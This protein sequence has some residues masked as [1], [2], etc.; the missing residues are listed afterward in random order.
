[1]GFMRQVTGKK[2]RRLGDDNWRKEGPESVLQA[3]G[4]EPL[5][6]YINKRQVMVAEWVDLQP[7]F[8]VCAKEI[9]YEVGGKF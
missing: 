8:E 4:T 7:I 9:G 5:R 2:A 6:D 1:M 3:S